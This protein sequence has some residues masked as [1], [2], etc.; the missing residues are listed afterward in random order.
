[1]KLATSQ[2]LHA[3]WSLLRGARSAP[4]RAEIDPSAI[5]GV[6]ADTFILEVDHSARYPIRISGARTNSLFARELKGASFIE[7]WQPAD[8]REI[9]TMLKSV[10][11]EAAAIVAGVSSDPTGAQ[12]L[13]LELLLLP[14]RHHGKTD[15]RILGSLAPVWLPSWLGLFPAGALSLLSLRVLGR[16]DCAPRQASH[17]PDE[18]AAA[19][20]FG[21]PPP[22]QRHG[23]LFV[24]QGEAPRR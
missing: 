11:D 12:A 16:A 10:A 13:D 5:R 22:F 14:L 23:H 19:S 21:R 17:A 3:Y 18:E 6:L 2:E 24:H 1:V 15:A 7:L 4:E 9:A 20:A 8:R